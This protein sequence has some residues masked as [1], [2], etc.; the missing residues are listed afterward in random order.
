MNRKLLVALAALFAWSAAWAADPQVEI[1]TMVKRP[2]D[3][4]VVTNTEDMF[5]A[6]VL[7]APEADPTI[8]G[9][10]ACHILLSQGT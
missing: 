8:R 1:K 7:A 4:A 10:V 5:L 2:E 6:S 9:L 3:D